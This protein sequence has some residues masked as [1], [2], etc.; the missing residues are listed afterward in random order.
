MKQII[1]AK[2]YINLSKKLQILNVFER[3]DKLIVISRVVSSGVNDKAFV[4]GRNSVEVDTRADHELPVEHYLIGF[5][6]RPEQVQQVIGNAV[7][8]QHISLK[9]D[10]KLNFWQPTGE[11]AAND[12]DGIEPVYPNPNI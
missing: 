9:A 1:T 8:L 10:S 5:N 3:A 11:R 6:I 7:N 2:A 12:D 4:K